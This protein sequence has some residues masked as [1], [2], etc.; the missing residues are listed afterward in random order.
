MEALL[1]TLFG[2]IVAVTV[3]GWV[4]LDKR[5]RFRVSIGVPPSIDT[6]AGKRIGFLSYLVTGAV[7]CWSSLALSQE[8]GVGLPLMGAA[9]LTFFLT[10]EFLTI[11]R[12][13]HR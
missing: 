11:R 1:Y 3:W 10:V 9:C 8:E 12:A 5:H 6:T 13:L 7:I 4:S 2:G